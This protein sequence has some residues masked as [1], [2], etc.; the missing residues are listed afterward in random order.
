MTIFSKWVGTVFTPSV[1][2]RLVSEKVLKAS[3][4]TV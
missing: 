4:L 2:N 3:I 1:K